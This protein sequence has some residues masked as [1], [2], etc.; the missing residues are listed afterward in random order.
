MYHPINQHSNAIL[1]TIANFGIPT[2]V[3][4]YKFSFDTDRSFDAILGNGWI[5]SFGTKKKVEF[6]DRVQSLFSKIFI[7]NTMP[8]GSQKCLFTKWKNVL[9]LQF[10]VIVFLYLPSLSGRYLDK[11]FSILIWFC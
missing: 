2:S 6:L 11:Y 7:T 10:F 5:E 3:C 4:L 1:D 9:Y 8:H